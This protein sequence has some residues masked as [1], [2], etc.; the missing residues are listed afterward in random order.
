MEGVLKAL[1]ASSDV[2]ASQI[3]VIS[4][5]KAQVRTFKNRIFLKKKNR[6]NLKGPVHTVHGSRVICKFACNSCDVACV[7]CEH[8][9]CQQLVSLFVWCAL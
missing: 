6:H 9:T 8:F 4:P 5:Y 3:G 2:P 7:L 1:L